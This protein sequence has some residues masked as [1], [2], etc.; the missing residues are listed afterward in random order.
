M[1][2]HTFKS[3]YSLLTANSTS[4]HVHVAKWDWI[5]VLPLP[6]PICCTDRR[7]NTKASFTWRIL[8]GG[9]LWWPCLPVLGCT[10]VQ[11]ILM[12]AVPLPSIGTE[13][14]HRHSHASEV[15]HIGICGCVCAADS[16]G[17]ACTGMHRFKFPVWTRP[18]PGTILS[19]ATVVKTNNNIYIHFFF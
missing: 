2:W 11:C 8:I 7:I 10:G 5:L 9:P 4:A 15:I 19:Q 17:T 3:L 16:N 1:R 6:H 13:W 14:L 12:Q 18:K